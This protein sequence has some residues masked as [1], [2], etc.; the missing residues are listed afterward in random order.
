MV[1]CPWIGFRPVQL[2]NR[3]LGKSLL[4]VAAWGRKTLIF[5]LP[6]K[7]RR[8]SVERRFMRRGALEKANNRDISELR[9]A[10]LRSP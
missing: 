10:A 6:N 1:V 9:R 8:M 3:G 5:G 2:G 4:P 7:I